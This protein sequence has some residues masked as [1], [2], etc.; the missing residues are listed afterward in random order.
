VW[1]S[2]RLALTLI[3]TLDLVKYCFVLKNGTFQVM[4]SMLVNEQLKQ[5]MPD[6]EGIDSIQ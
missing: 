6:I 1:L 5:K 2:R 4:G 3:Y